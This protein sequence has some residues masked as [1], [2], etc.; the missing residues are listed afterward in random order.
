M[1]TE[2]PVIRG[3]Y[4]I[5][6]DMADTGQL[7]SLVQQAIDGG[8]TLLQYRC[9]TLP[10][11]LRSAQAKALAAQCAAQRVTLIVNDDTHLARA[12]RAAGVHLGK[13]DD[14]VPSKQ[15]EDNIHALLVGIS[16]YDSLPRALKAQALGADY[17]A[18]GSMF[19]SPTKPDAVRA[20]LSLLR[21]AKRR[22]AV[23]VVAIGGITLAHMDELMDAGAD[24]VAV[25]SALFDAPDVRKAAQH[26]NACFGE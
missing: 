18:F 2:R 10:A 11:E 16:C 6:P 4:G 15:P 5:T 19:S 17:V 21:E 7:Q 1:S 8:L 26:F 13:T 14:S 12:S 22:L 20:P 3:L 24:A 9:K 25:I 23:P